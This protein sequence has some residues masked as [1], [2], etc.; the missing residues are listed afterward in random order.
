M[1]VPEGKGSETLSCFRTA[2]YHLT[3]A[4][5]QAMAFSQ[6]A[7]SDQTLAYRQVINLYPTVACC[8]ELASC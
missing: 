6:K 7:I 2:F 4:S 8:Q 3:P 1:A 5:D